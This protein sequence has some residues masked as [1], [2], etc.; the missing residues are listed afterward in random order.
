MGLIYIFIQL[1]VSILTILIRS[2]VEKKKKRVNFN[3]TV[4]LLE[5]DLEGFFN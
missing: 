3:F 1:V 4:T 2:I 5:R